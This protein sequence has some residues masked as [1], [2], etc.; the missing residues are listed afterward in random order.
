[1]SLCCC[2]HKNRITKALTVTWGDVILPSWCDLF[3][4]SWPAVNSKVCARGSNSQICILKLFGSFSA[5]ENCKN[6]R[7]LK[8]KNLLDMCWTITSHKF[9]S[10]PTSCA[11]VV[12]LVKHMVP[13]VG[14]PL[15]FFLSPALSLYPSCSFTHYLAFFPL[16]LSKFYTHLNWILRSAVRPSLAFIFGAMSPCVCQR[17]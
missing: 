10:I 11:V 13:I 3:T 2:S 12:H 17:T 14:R 5:S 16:T 6:I 15:C 1:M 7:A 9:L 4:A 8:S